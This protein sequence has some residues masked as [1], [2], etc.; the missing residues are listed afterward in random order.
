MGKKLEGRF[1]HLDIEKRRILEAS[2][3]DGVPF[4]KAAERMGIAVSSVSCEVKRNR[5]YDGP[6]RLLSRDKNDCAMLK[7]CSVR[8]ICGIKG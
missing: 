7:T 3:N 8:G 1:T 6:S 4:A 5:R 2:L